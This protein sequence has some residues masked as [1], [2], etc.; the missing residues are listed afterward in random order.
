LQRIDA[1]HRGQFPAHR[2]DQIGTDLE[3]D[4]VTAGADGSIREN[5][6]RLTRRPAFAPSFLTFTWI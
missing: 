5:L 2:L 3:F 4:V 1:V 6:G